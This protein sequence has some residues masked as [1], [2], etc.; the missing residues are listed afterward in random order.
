MVEWRYKL[1]DIKQGN[2][3]PDTSTL[4]EEEPKFQIY[5]DFHFLGEAL[6]EVEC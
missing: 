6:G 2:L 5:L 3:F 4:E 1:K